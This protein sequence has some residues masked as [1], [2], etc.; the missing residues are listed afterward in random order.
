MNRT[1]PSA[2]RNLGTAGVEGPEL[3]GVGRDRVGAVD[4]AGVRDDERVAPLG[5]QAVL[6]L[7]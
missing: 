2:K 4:L 6:G 3:V 1:E 7:E 5:I